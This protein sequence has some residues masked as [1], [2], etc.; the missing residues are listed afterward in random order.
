MDI[1]EKEAVII[2]ELMAHAWHEDKGAKG[3]EELR[4]RIR[5]SFPDIIVPLEDYLLELI[6]G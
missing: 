3:D 2:L 4:V 1:T 6:E 5:A